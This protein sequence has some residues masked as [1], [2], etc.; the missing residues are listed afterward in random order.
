MDTLINI[1][2]FPVVRIVY[3]TLQML[4]LLKKSSDTL[5]AIVGESASSGKSFEALKYVFILIDVLLVNM[6]KTFYLLRL[7]SSY[8]LEIILAIAFGHVV[9]LQRGESDELIKSMDVLFGDNT[10]GRIEKFIMFY[11]KQ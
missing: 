8:T 11:S 9:N 2:V 5:V 6:K 10:E 4:P 1:Q 7:Y 3:C